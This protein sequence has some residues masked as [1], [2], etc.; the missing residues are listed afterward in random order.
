MSLH[1]KG[2]FK[3]RGNEVK[4][5]LPVITFQ[6]EGL[7]FY[8][9]PPLDI[10]GYGKTDDEAKA[11]FEET[12]NQFFDYTTNKKTFLAELK[13]LGW[14]VSKAISQPPSLKDMINN[15]QYLAEIFEEKQYK[16][17]DQTISIPALV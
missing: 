12:L 1:F 17:F 10:T 4:F 6:E 7:Y 5:N 9:S 16:K 2:N 15:N 11:S 14:K 13:R 3:N 8:Y